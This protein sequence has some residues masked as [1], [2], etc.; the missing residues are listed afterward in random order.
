MDSR[1]RA[2]E[3]IKLCLLYLESADDVHDDCCRTMKDILWI[4]MASKQERRRVSPAKNGK[5]K[6]FLLLVSRLFDED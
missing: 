2:G 4:E 6:S 1:A 5:A 3:S